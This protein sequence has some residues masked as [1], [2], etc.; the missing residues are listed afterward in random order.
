MN[1]YPAQVQD[2]FCA[3]AWIHANAATYGFDTE[4]IAA[5]GESAGG[6]L[7][8]M[9]GTVE[10]PRLTWKAVRPRCRRRIGF[11]VHPYLWPLDYTNLTDYPEAGVQGCLE[12]YLG[13][14]IGEASQTS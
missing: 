12:P 14:T 5:I 9:L 2:A 8:A 13:T 10:I 4:H 11:K 1:T 7:V 6:Y 3:L